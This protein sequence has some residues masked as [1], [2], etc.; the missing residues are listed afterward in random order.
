MTTVAV[1]YSCRADE[2]LIDPVVKALVDEGMTVFKVEAGKQSVGEGIGAV[3]APCDRGEIVK[4]ALDCF[5]NNVPIVHVDAGEAELESSTRDVLNRWLLTRMASLIFTNTEEGRQAVIRS[6]E[7]PWRVHSVGYTFL[8][9]I[10]LKSKGE[11]MEKYGLP[12]D[13]DIVIYNPDVYS[14]ERTRKDMDKIFDMLDKF[15]IILKP[16]SDTNDFIVNEYIENHY[17]IGK[18]GNKFDTRDEFLSALKYCKRFMGNSSVILH[19]SPYFNVECIHVGE[20]NR[21]RKPR[22]IKPEELGASERIA[23]TIKD[24]LDNKSREELLR[25][26]V[27]L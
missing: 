26:K 6:G 3:I 19:E 21:G 14:V 12:E 16:N 15:T 20:R 2:G 7:E 22:L 24:T 23:K 8:D 17:Y 18:L 13:Y 27:L 1:L 25:K 11:I 10:E 4:A 9:G 5:H